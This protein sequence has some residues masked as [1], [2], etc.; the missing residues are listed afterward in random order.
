MRRKLF[1]VS[2]VT[3]RR[4]LF[5][6]PTSSRRKLFSNDEENKNLPPVPA[7]E[8]K[9]IKCMDC[10]KTYEYVGSNTA[11][12]CTKCGSDRFEFITNIS[13]PDDINPGDLNPIDKAFSEKRRK[14]FND[15]SEVETNAM[16]MP[17]LDK[18]TNSLTSDSDVSKLPYLYVCPDC[19]TELHTEE[20]YVDYVICPNCGG[21]RC[22]KI[23]GDVDNSK[24]EEMKNAEENAYSET[25]DELNELLSKHK[26]ESVNTEDLIAELHARDIYDEVG[27]I[28]GLV[29]SGYA[30]EIS[31]DQVQF[32]D[33]ADIQYRMFSKLVISVTKEFDIDPIMDKE[34]AID[35]LAE[36][37]PG[38]S[39]MILKKSRH[40]M[41]P[42]AVTFSDKSYLKDSGIES[43][44]R[45]AYGGQ[46]MAMKDFVNLLSDEYPDA[47]EDIIDL[48]EASKAIKVNG[49]KVLI[50]K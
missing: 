14:L 2:E 9:I 50:S 29:E 46:T 36:R 5:S 35:S 34:S 18:T 22:R 39:I 38:K 31:D 37:F 47:P 41:T 49:G 19:G 8:K 27:G 1:S 7:E 15:M 13:N 11:P 25:E 26:G 12:L 30:E 23:N 44:I 45:I 4:K 10:G 6:T 20:N 24:A 21:K 33:V 3:S 42:E 28:E 40:M 16:N 48:L 43:D 32:S 17:P